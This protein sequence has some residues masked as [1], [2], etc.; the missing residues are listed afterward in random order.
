MCCFGAGKSS[1]CTVVDESTTRTEKDQLKWIQ[2]SPSCWSLVV[3]LHQY[4]R[5]CWFITETE[6]RLSAG[7]VFLKPVLWLPRGFTLL[8]FWNMFL[9]FLLSQHKATKNT[10]HM[11]PLWSEMEKRKN[12]PKSEWFSVKVLE[13]TCILRLSTFLKIIQFNMIKFSAL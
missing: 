10:E 6:M 12:C 9:L 5:F 3:F 8:H 2:D 13:C 7:I 1:E 11:V 4:G